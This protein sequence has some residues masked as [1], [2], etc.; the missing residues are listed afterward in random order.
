MTQE[1]CIF[2]KIVAGDIPAAKIYEDDH[3]FGFLDIE[4]LSAGHALLVPKQHSPNLAQL[5][6][7]EAQ[8]LA[9]ALGPLAR[10]VV[11]AVQAD[12]FNVLCNNGAAAGQLIEQVHYHI[13]P[14]KKGDGLF[15]RWPGE[16]YPK[17]RI[18]HIAQ[19]IIKAL[20]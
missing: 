9:A 5:P 4:P 3:V 6:V 17:G 14:R 20:S 10:A 15:T 19:E 13:I 7:A 11:Q 18:E 16:K 1:N 12:G 2:C 8:H